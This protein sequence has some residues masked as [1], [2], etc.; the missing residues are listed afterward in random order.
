MRRKLHILA[1]GASLALVLAIAVMWPVS[2][3][4][5]PGFT[6][7]SR[8][9]GC[10]AEMARGLLAAGWGTDYAPPGF[11]VAVMP[12]PTV[13]RTH[14]FGFTYIPKFGPGGIAYASV[15]L[16]FLALCPTLA[17]W[18]LWQRR[19]GRPPNVCRTCG[20]DLRATPDRCPECGT[21]PAERARTAA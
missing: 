17:G 1:A 20:Y 4:W 18:L 12:E 9:F 10:G 21:V 3:W 5:S 8:W 7:Q 11:K 13:Y 2:F 15:P 6:Y 16:W 14:R 19:A